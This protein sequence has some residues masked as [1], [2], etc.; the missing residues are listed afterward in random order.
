MPGNVDR[1]PWLIISATE[2]QALLD[3]ALA[4]PRPSATLRRAIRVL[5][6]QL[7]WLWDGRGCQPSAKA[8][9]ERDAAQ[10]RRGPPQH[11]DPLDGADP[12]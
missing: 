2:A 10:A 3:V 1:R 5:E 8:A 7:G 4:E 11:C 12:A 6:N 9:V